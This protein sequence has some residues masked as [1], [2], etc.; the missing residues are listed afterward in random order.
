MSDEMLIEWLNEQVGGNLRSLKDVAKGKEICEVL[1]NYSGAYDKSKLIK[2]GK[3]V[4][5]RVHNFN[6]C[7]EMYDLLQLDFNYDINSLIS[8][9]KTDLRN[10]ITEIS[11]LD[12]EVQQDQ[13][14]EED[15]SEPIDLTELISELHSDLQSKLEK[16]KRLN[17]DIEN[18][19]EERDFIFDK[20][21]RIETA[22]TRYSEEETTSIVR[23][24]GI[25]GPEF[26]I[27]NQDE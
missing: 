8:G 17:V 5:E 9:K 18:S 21:R 14:N 15:S 25:T 10:L 19:V 23:I 26:K 27:V 13:S 11:S 4:D 1:V 6:L 22:A 2:P 12:E 20:L 3:T 7:K 16:L 24:L